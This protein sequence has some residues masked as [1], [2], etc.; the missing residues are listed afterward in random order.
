MGSIA[1]SPDALRAKLADARKRIESLESE[2]GKTVALRDLVLR[3][4]YLLVEHLPLETY[5]HRMLEDVVRT[6][7]HSGPACILLADQE[8]RNLRVVAPIHYD[9][10]KAE[11]Y[12]I[13]L[14]D[15]FQYKETGGNYTHTIII[16]HI[17]R[18]MSPEAA[19]ILDR[20]D[21]SIV[22]CS[23]SSPIFIDGKLYGII[24]LD[25]PSNDAFDSDDVEV[26]EYVRTQVAT[27]LRHFELLE[28]IEH[29]SRYDQLTGFRTR[30]AVPEIETL[31]ARWQNEGN[32]ATI[33]LAMLDMDGLKRLNDRFGHSA[34]DEAIRRF[35]R[36]LQTCLSKDDF[37]IRMGGDEFLVVFPDRDMGEAREIL[38]QVQ[39]S[40]IGIPGGSLDHYSLGSSWS[41][42]GSRELSGASCQDAELPSG[43]ILSFSCG[44]AETG[45]DGDCFD[46][47]SSRADRRLYEVKAVRSG[48]LC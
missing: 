9:P 17:S 36:T 33:T 16:R 35:S 10:V 13:S 42:S 47:V 7:G 29:L 31:I 15:T 37:V 22:D 4:N 48:C 8:G 12:Y 11:G 40:L 30:W 2:L 45:P 19:P 21:G 14:K 26:M 23:L 18:Y 1:E 5:L 27:V 6:L 38:E 34:G 24:N 20:T 3:L 43:H 39:R 44:I 28:K 25:S 32:P 41:G 46:A